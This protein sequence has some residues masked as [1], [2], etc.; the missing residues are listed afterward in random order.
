[1]S[2]AQR[3][4]F[5][6]GDREAVGRCPLCGR[7]FCRECVTEHDSRLVC[8]SCLEKLAHGM[9]PRRTWS[10]PATRLALAAAGL[11]IA[12]IFFLTLGAILVRLPAQGHE[13]PAG[14][15][16]EPK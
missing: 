16:E 10:G 3:R 15:R 2:L 12:W 5:H 14:Q 8:R 4:C 11:L 13:N 7:F 9:E 6:H 1:M